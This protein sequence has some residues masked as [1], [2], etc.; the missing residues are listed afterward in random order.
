V[1]VSAGALRFALASFRALS[2]LQFALVAT[3]AGALL[4]PLSLR[5]PSLEPTSPPSGPDGKVHAE[6][7]Y[8][9]LPLAF[10]RDAGRSGPRVDFL[11]RTPGGTAFVGA[12]GATL[13]LADK[14]RSEALRLGLAG[15][16][17][18][19]PRAIGRLPGEVNY[20]VGNTPS[21]WRTGITTFERI[22]Y[23]AVWP[24][25]TLDWH[26]D[27]RNL[28]YDFRLAPGADPDRIAVRMK[29]A[30]RL[31]LAGDGDLLIDVGGITVRQRSPVAY[32]PSAEGRTPVNAGFAVGDRT[33]R[34]RLGPYDTSRRL[35]IDP[36]VLSYST[37]LAGG[38][39]DR[40]TGIAVDSSGSAYVAGWTDS[41]DFDV[42]G[43]AGVGHIE[44]DSASTD[45][46]VA[47][48]NPA[49][50]ALVY[51]TYLGGDG[52]D[53]A[54]AV[55]V[56]GSGAA[57]V[58]GNTASTDFNI[59]GQVEADT[60]GSVDAFVSKL[61]PAG[62]ALDYSTYLGG[63]GFDSAHAIAVDGSGDAYITGETASTDLNTIGEFEGNSPGSGADANDVFVSKLDPTQTGTSSLLYSTYLGGSSFDLGEG[64]AV[65]ASGKAFVTG[66]TNSSDF[67]VTGTAGV[68]HI[69]GDTPGSRDTF[70][71]K[72]DPAQTGANSLVY[73][74][75]LGGDGADG[76]NAIA[77]DGSGAAHVTGF[78]LSTDFNTTGPIEG[79]SAA[80]DAFVSKLNP[81][82]NALAYSTYLGGDG[83]ESGNGIDVDAS[84][85]AY[86]TGNTSSTDFDTVGQIE[87]DAPGPDAF[88]SKLNPAGNALAYST[89]LGGSD[90]D[91][92]IGIAVDS[93]GAAYL[94]GLTNSTD[95]DTAGEIEGDPGD[96]DNDAFV[97]KLTFAE[98]QPPP[99][100]L[101]EVEEGDTLPPDTQITSAPKKKTMK[102][103]ASFEFISIEPGSTFECAL[104]GQT[105][106]V[107]CGSPY[108]VKVKKG[109]H[110]FQVRATDAAGNTDPTP[111]GESW[112]VK[113]KKKG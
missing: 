75:Y 64:I 12:S 25:I 105:L 22:R 28:E 60:A 26:G 100:S 63:D 55:A 49:G 73:S 59:V 96:N 32:Q 31:R 39:E 62:N 18:A 4:L 111:A 54:R 13:A 19:E 24:G 40:G 107:P 106:K 14:D 110:T 95:F 11:A 53:L 51:S 97:S 45:A 47:K 79:N 93:S 20:L 76:G 112:K 8:G 104:D 66:V 78:T 50:N 3:L 94:V 5:A 98:P 29:G 30:D 16:T 52:A 86:V 41:T 35:V 103:Q 10:E 34:F 74:T 38:A 101:P 90:G 42:T 1:S 88:A 65:D 113:K 92:A 7:S 68:G 99:S 70:V 57:Y 108:T 43:S 69:E 36:V 102:K 37:Y 21:E 9:Q 91:F 85:A 44:G 80:G 67:D 27:Q 17:A 87:A 84:G 58:S 82:G 71:S 48:L 2:V 56:D 15:S 81:A 77:V 33:V 72:L 6:R 83:D 109:R 89:Y 23:P 46:F 61:N